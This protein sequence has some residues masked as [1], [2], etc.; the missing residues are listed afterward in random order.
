[1]PGARIVSTNA[2]CCG[3]PCALIPIFIQVKSCLDLS[4]FSSNYLRL[5]NYWN[6]VRQ[7]LAKQGRHYNLPRRFGPGAAV[8][9]SA[10]R[11]A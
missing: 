9:G 3:P 2:A 4:C 10:R 11:F 6:S 7:P 8:F 5:S 1:M